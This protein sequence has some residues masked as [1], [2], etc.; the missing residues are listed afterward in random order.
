MIKFVSLLYTLQEDTTCNGQI[1]SANEL[2]F[3]A[4]H[5]SYMQENTNYYWGQKINNKSLLFQQKIL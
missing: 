4:E 2:V 3:K 1:I 5:I